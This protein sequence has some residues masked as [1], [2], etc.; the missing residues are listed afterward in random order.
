MQV[1]FGRDPTAAE[2]SDLLKLTPQ[3]LRGRVFAA[4][5]FARQVLL[6]FFAADPGQMIADSTR[7]FHAYLEELS[8]DE[9]AQVRDLIAALPRP[10]DGSGH[11]YVGFHARRMEEMLC[12]LLR[13]HQHTP[14]ASLL[15]IGLSPFI[16]TYKRLLPEVSVTLADIWQH[17]EARL[18]D[19]GVDA[20]HRVDLNRSAI[21]AQHG[22]TLGATYDA[23]VFTEVIE[24][25][26]V[27][28]LEAF[29][30]LLALLQPGGCLFVSTPNFFS[31]GAV[32][33]ILERLNPQPRYSRKEGNDDTHYHLREYSLRELLEAAEQAGGKVLF[34]ALSDCWDRDQLGERQSSRLPVALR[35]NLVLVLG[36][37]LAAAA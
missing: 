1:L 14:I 30:D 25:L 29:T 33:R 12:F 6:Q 21:A 3:A 19:L 31:Y 15:D 2:L 8:S 34:Y 35:S 18:R 17:A 27:D 10:D 26:L 4:P 28:P 22:G 24:H 5:G 36:K 37:P 20:F 11:D 13:R 23:I 16:Q 32:L 9:V 7:R